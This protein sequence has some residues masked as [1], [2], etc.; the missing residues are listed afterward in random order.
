MGDNTCSLRVL[1]IGNN[2]FSD[3]S[4]EILRQALIKN[5]SLNKI[6][7]RGCKFSKKKEKE[8][9]QKSPYSLTD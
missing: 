5:N 9:F 1:Y 6:D 4:F 8:G 2:N 7:L 3:D